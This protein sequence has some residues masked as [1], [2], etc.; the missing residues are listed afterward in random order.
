MTEILSNDNAH[1]KPTEQ[2]VQPVSS[3][4]SIP[5]IPSASSAASLPSTQA[6]LREINPPSP[7]LM[8][9]W[10]MWQNLRQHH[11]LVSNF[12]KRDLR[13]KYRNSVL[14]YFWSLLEPLLLAGVYFVLFTILGNRPE[15]YIL[16]VLCGVITWTFFNK[17][18]NGSLTSLTRS[19]GMIKQVYFPR[20]IFSFTIVGSNLCIACLSLVITIPFMYHFG[21]W[22]SIYLLM[23]PLGLLLTALL[24]LGLGLAMACLNAINRDIE[25][26]FRFVTRAGF[27]L[28]PVLWT[29]NMVPSSRQKVLDYLLL[30][31]MVVPITMVRNGID[32]N[33]LG[34]D[35]VYV[36]YSVVFCL[37][38]FLLGS[39]VFK[40][41]EAEVVKKV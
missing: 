5:S 34:I 13:L 25:H 19:G 9:P 3:S 10:L 39:M 33:G 37:L 35:M 21:I 24:A 28:S 36:V 29:L 16:W 18:L 27:F 1:P 23:V 38:S 7:F 2:R 30:N 26:F 12:I 14:G 31:P 22:P 40:R 4:S 20:E 15:R 17:S 41:Y 6:E 8:G 11:Y 32:G